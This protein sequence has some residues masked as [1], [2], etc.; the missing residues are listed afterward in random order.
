VAED[1]VNRLRKLTL[2]CGTVGLAVGA[3]HLVEQRGA[4]V[5]TAVEPVSAGPAD[6]LPPMPVRTATI[7]TP[8]L[9][10]PSETAPR[11]LRVASPDPANA[12]TPASAVDAETT[13]A[14]PE[15]AAPDCTAALQLIP[16]P[17]GE[18]SVWL[19]APCAAEARVELR[20]E[21]LA[22]TYRTLPSGN[23][24][25]T[26][27]ALSARAIVAARLPGG[28]SVIA[29][30]EVPDLAGLRRMGVAWGGADAFQLV[31]SAGVAP[32]ML[33]DA[34]V[35]Q[36]LVAAVMTLPPGA[37]APG[38]EAEVTPATCGRTMAGAVIVQ[39]GPVSAASDLSLAMPTCE[40]VGDILV[41]NN[42]LPDVTLAA[43]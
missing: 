24:F 23:L 18:M 39:N 37:E 31:P 29:T 5:P 33:G 40:A 43:R 15:P 12:G 34:G 22:L 36:P 42:L 3:G 25:V 14:V 35:D 7:V 26:L 4:P 27:P 30:T 17:G 19:K 6:V 13:A 21:G 11:F 28:D 9:P 10:P 2:I 20:H 16:L 8:A 1:A 38:L 32:V 41:L